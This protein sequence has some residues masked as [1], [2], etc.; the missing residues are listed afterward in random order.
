VRRIL[1]LLSAA[2]ALAGCG[3][4]SG[5]KSGG[6][7]TTVAAP[8]ASQTLKVSEKEFSITP[9]SLTVARP[10]T[11]S[12]AISNDGHVG[13]AFVVEGKGVESKTGTIDPGSSTTLSVTLSKPGK[14]ELYC[15]IDGHAG[16]GMKATLT[17]QGAASSPGMNGT[18]P[19][20]TTTRGGTTTSN[21]GGYGY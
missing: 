17:V 3:G 16:K 20:P 19:A 12:F 15:P 14:Y 7:T 8:A 2:L 18:S 6:G 21:Q 10:G 4:T 11:Y 13:H 9:D 1:L 5:S